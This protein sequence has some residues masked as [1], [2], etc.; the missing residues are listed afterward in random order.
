MYDTIKILDKKFTPPYEIQPYPIGPLADLCPSKTVHHM[1][2][3]LR[4]NLVGHKKR[5]ATMLSLFLW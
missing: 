4:S 5:I 2:A 3:E 1:T